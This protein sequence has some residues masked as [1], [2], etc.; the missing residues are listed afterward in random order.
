MSSLCRLTA[1]PLAVF[2]DVAA[3]TSSTSSTSGCAGI[4]F[5]TWILKF[6]DSAEP[7]G[8][9]PI[10]FGESRIVNHGFGEP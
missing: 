2:P 10:T 4:A 3:C 7:A 1:M 6:A 5:D 9:L 8:T